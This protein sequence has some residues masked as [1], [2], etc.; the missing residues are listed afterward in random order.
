MNAATDVRSRL[1]L[2]LCACFLTALVIAD[3]TAG[4][5]FRL[6]ALEISVGVIPFPLTFVLTDLVNE[7]YGRQGARAMT[8]IGAGMLVLAF[9]LITIARL[10]PVAE[11]S[12]VPGVAFDAVFGISGR[13]FAASLAAFLLG[14]IADIQAFHAVKRLTRSRHLWLRATGST[15]LSQVVDTSVVTG[16]ALAGTKPVLEIAGIVG[17]NYA[18]KMV[19]AILLTPLLYGL[20]DLLTA[21]WGIEAAPPEADVQPA[22]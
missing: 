5:F 2:V 13:F 3:V 11:G 9:V 22:A 20:H 16:L 19:V 7:Y 18:Y 14:Q 4:K 1:Y 21:R 17:A 12:P 10:L 15:A 6:G 8:L